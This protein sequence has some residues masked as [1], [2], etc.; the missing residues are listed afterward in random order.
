[1]RNF[2]KFKTVR[3]IVEGKSW[4]IYLNEMHGS[5]DKFI[6]VGTANLNTYHILFMLVLEKDNPSFH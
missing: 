6:R 1:M 2:R 4:D 3:E 5:I